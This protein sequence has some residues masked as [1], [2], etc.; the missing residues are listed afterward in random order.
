MSVLVEVP[1]VVEAMVKSGVTAA[2]ETEFEMETREY[3]EVVPI[4]T[5]PV[6][7]PYALRVIAPV[8]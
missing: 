8:P 7:Y 5:L 2:V 4:P 3:G 6:P 1:P